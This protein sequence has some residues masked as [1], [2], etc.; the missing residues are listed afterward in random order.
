MLTDEIYEHLTYDGVQAVS[1]LKAVP[2][3]ADLCVILNGVARPMP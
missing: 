1:I 3:L 2:G